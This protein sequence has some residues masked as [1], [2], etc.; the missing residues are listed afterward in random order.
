MTSLT[1]NPQPPSKKIFFECRLE[2]LPHLCHR[3]LPGLQSIP[4]RRNSPAKPCA[5]RR[6]FSEN[7]RILADAK[8]LILLH[9][10]ILR[11]FFRNR[12]YIKLVR[13][14]LCCFNWSDQSVT[15]TCEQNIIE[16]ILLSEQTVR[17]PYKLFK[18]DLKAALSP[19]LD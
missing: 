18:C 1:K 16:N 4:D 10:M 5:F 8:E 17:R 15:F 13:R 2:D 14:T 7:P 9:T 3:L 6:F 12:F 11:F 19:P